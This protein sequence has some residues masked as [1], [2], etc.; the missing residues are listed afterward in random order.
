MIGAQ[1]YCRNRGLAHFIEEMKTEENKMID[2]NFENVL[3]IMILHTIAV[4]IGVTIGVTIAFKFIDL[5]E[6]NHDRKMRR[7]D[8]LHKG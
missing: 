2:V 7:L 1:V 4:T 5:I 8:H 3:I 6:W